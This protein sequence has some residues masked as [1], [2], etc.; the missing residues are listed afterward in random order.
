MSHPTPLQ[1][2]LPRAVNILKLMLQLCITHLQVTTK[3]GVMCYGGK[4]GEESDRGPCHIIL[5]RALNGVFSYLDSPKRM[6]S[7]T[8]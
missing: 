5:N 4:D 6:L 8:K 3:R 7:S 2:L 1:P